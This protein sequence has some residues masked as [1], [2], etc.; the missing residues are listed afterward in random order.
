M[1][2]LLIIMPLINLILIFLMVFILII[3]KKNMYDQEKM[4]SFECGF[5]PKL[6]ARLPFSLHFFILTI[7]FLIFDVEITL[8]MPMIM[9]IMSCNLIYWYYINLF[10]LMI[11]LGGLFHEWIQGFINWSI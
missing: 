6:S 10:F 8:I 2:N 11:L 1:F 5:N 3:S 7:I 9:T 4:S